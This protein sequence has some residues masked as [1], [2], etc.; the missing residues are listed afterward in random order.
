MSQHLNKDFAQE[1]ESRIGTLENQIP[2]LGVFDEAPAAGEAW[3]PDAMSQKRMLDGCASGC[4]SFSW[5]L[6]DQDLMG[7]LVFPRWY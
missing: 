7:T 4:M 5:T 1:S 2:Y 3:P 6:L